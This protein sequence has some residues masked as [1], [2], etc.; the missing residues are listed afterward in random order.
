MK[1]AIFQPDARRSERSPLQALEA[2]LR[3]Q[4]GQGFDLVLC[5]ELFVSGYGNADTIRRLAS[6]TDGELVENL[7]ALAREHEVAIACGYPEK[8]GE[9]LYNS[10]L[11]LSSRGDLLANHRKRVL[12]M[13]YEKELFE[14]G[15]RMTVFDLDNGWRAALLVC[16]EVEFP[17][18]V[19]A[20]T[21]EGAQ[22]ILVPTALGRDWQ[23]VSRQLIPTRAFENGVFIAY[24]NFAGEDEAGGYLG[25]SV[26]VSPT[27]QE[28]ARAG[29]KQ[30]LIGAELDMQAI[31]SART[32]LPYL[33]D[34]PDVC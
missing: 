27:G 29:E 28:L 12:P 1:L 5:P 25:D 9:C 31:A 8:E 18:A 11:C 14:K 19:R 4:T 10:A 13:A 16:Y 33:A 26:I 21:L 17:E 32:R 15:S 3:E 7:A 24:A 30:A 20:C 6:P 2:A 22:L 23:V 34:Y